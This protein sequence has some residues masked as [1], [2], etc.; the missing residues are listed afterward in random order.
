M[1]L[2]TLTSCEVLPALTPPRSNSQSRADFFVC[3]VD[4]YFKRSVADGE[5]VTVDE[6]GLVERGIAFMRGNL[7]VFEL[8]GLQVSGIS[9]S[10]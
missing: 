6:L 9:T 3:H 5:L 4:L 1:W 10:L 2:K 8:S 7:S